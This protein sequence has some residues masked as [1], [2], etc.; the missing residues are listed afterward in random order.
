[1]SATHHALEGTNFGKGLQSSVVDRFVWKYCRTPL[2]A[3]VEVYDGSRCMDIH[4]SYNTNIGI[5]LLQ[6]ILIESGVVFISTLILDVSATL[7][8]PDACL[9]YISQR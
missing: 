9:L 2:Y 3:L 4:I 6:M 5:H 7:T 1:M 8:L